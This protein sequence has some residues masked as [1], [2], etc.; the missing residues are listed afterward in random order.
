MSVPSFKTFL[1]KS[2]FNYNKASLY[3]E[4]YSKI[5]DENLFNEEFY[6]EK[7]PNIK[8]SGI[9]PL[10][11]YLF[12]GY[13][14]HKIPALNFDSNIY[15]DKYPSV[16]QLN[17]NPLV[18]YVMYGKKEGKK[19]FLSPALNFYNKLFEINSLFLNNYVFEVEP[20]VSIIVLN[21]NGLRHLELLFKDFNVNTNYDNFEIIVV[22]NGSSDGSVE[23]LESLSNDL[24]IKIIKNSENKSFSEANN[25]AVDVCNGDYVLLLNNDMEPTYGWLNEMMGAMIYNDNVG[26]VGAK[27]IYPYYY[28]EKNNYKSF[29]IQHVGDIF[30][31]RIKP[32]CAYAYNKNKFEQPYESKVNKS[33]QVAAVTAA[34][35]LIKK[36]IYK[37]LN[38]LNEEYFYGFEDVDFSLNLN[39]AGYEI[40]YCSAALL[41]HHES[42]TRINDKKE[43]LKNNELNTR[44]LWEKQGSYITQKI[45][46]DKIHNIKFFTE[47]PLKFTFLI[48]EFNINLKNY[49]LVSNLAKNL[50]KKD[51]NVDLLTSS[52]KQDAGDDTD[53]LISFSKEYDI[54]KV[55]CRKNSVKILYLDEDFDFNNDFDFYDIILTEKNK[56]YN[57]LKKSFS[58]SSFLVNL[59]SNSCEE[60]M[61]IIEEC[62]LNKY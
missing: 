47:K 14:E 55:N 46:L 28:D 40:L 3:K 31:E 32:C 43:Y 56:V 4:A 30:D 16:K 49:D 50:N 58:Q 5:L 20:L 57:E 35:I 37:D 61:N 33:N 6:I 23:F 27:L 26:A 8:N 12:Y 51:F 9:N 48:E 11:H 38:G 24:P 44:T 60:M 17:I 36:S 42:S 39:K 10:L 19:S 54:K 15:L 2:K 13:K 41:F 59:N 7:Y 53:V 52:D 25:Q 1:I 21:R 62:I 18:H 45:F 34:A 22:D 29:L